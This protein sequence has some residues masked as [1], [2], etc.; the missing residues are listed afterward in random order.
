MSDPMVG[1]VSGSGLDLRP[2]LDEVYEERP[3][4]EV[5]GLVSGGVAGHA[6]RFLLGS[7]GET[8]VVLQCGRVH[9]YEGLSFPEVVRPVEALIGFGANHLIFTNAVGG[10]LPGMEPGHLVAATEV[11]TWPYAAYDLPQQLP[12]ESVIPGCDTEGRYLWMH[13]PCYE[14]RAEIAALRAMGVA[15]VGMSTA[16]GVHRCK[17]L[18]IPAAIVSLVTNLCGSGEKLTHAHV[19]DTARKSSARLCRVLRESIQ[20]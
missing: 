18:G 15:T 10:L 4:A 9:A 17:Q 14:T 3:F 5:P 1:I 19:L 12:L 7:V 11:R 16:P 20:A 13:G 8:R 2:L 6:C